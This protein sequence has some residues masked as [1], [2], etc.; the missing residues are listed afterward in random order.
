[1]RHVSSDMALITH[2]L[3]MVSVH[4]PHSQ[5]ASSPPVSGA[6]S[7]EDSNQKKRETYEKAMAIRLEERAG[8]LAVRT[9]EFPAGDLAGAA[10][11][12]LALA[13]YHLAL[14]QHDKG[15]QWL[16]TALAEAPKDNTRLLSMIEHN[17]IQMQK[18]L[19]LMSDTS[20]TQQLH[21]Q[22]SPV[23]ESVP[24]QE[25]FEIDRSMGAVDVR[26]GSIR[27]KSGHDAAGEEE[28]SES[29]EANRS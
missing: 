14:L 19:E 12:S 11:A 2:A 9:S 13:T 5:T 17:M 15:R 29:A 22:K 6:Q 18:C 8:W 16:D 10:K 28:A 27:S 25:E 21:S 20:G 26:E 4:L 7:L 1:M 24:L 23:A 3:M